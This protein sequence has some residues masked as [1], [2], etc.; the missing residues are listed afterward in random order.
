MNKFDFIIGT[1]LIA[2]LVSVLLAVFLITV[3]TKNKLSNRLFAAFILFSAV[4]ISGFFIYTYINNFPNL[5]I[6]RWTTSLLIMPAFYLYILSVCY[7]GFRLKYKHLLH[8]IPFVIANLILIPHFYS[9]VNENKDYIFS[10]ATHTPEMLFFRILTEAQFFFYITGAFIV[11][12]RFQKI[13]RENYTDGSTATYKWLMQITV[14]SLVAHAIVLVKNLFKYTD[15]EFVFILLNVFVSLTAL[16]ILC[17]FIL[18]AL[19]YPDLFRGVDT[20]L[21]PVETLVADQP[22]TTRLDP[23]LEEKIKLIRH[24][25]ESEEPYLDPSL[26]VQQLASQIKMPVRDLSI[27]INHHLNQH[28]FDFVNEYRINKASKLLKDPAKVKFTVL[29]ILY[30][31]G[32]NSK[33]SFNTAFKK[34]TGTTPTLYR[35][36]SL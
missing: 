34:Y 31:V 36:N 23:A 9:A 29:E 2:V 10:H 5:E 1:A 22:V 33:S 18:K 24:Y 3:K 28:F 32:F 7:T 14:I 8:L 12:R 20:E 30:E 13:Y 27:L 35:N 17:W 26:T 15:D 21:Q 4:D 11:L 16:A 6:F 19:Y 25:M